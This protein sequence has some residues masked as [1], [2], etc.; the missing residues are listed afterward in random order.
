MVQVIFLTPEVK[1]TLLWLNRNEV[2]HS[3]VVDAGITH[4]ENYY[5]NTLAWFTVRGTDVR[6]T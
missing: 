3:N 1:I 4:K 6:I 5:F 2:V